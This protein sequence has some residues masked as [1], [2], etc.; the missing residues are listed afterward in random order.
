MLD[1]LVLEKYT[2][3]RPWSTIS[4]QEHG[5]IIEIV[6]DV[7]VAILLSLIVLLCWHATAIANGPTPYVEH[8]HVSKK[9]TYIPTLLLGII[10]TFSIKFPTAIKCV[11]GPPREG[12]SMSE[13]PPTHAHGYRHYNNLVAQLLRNTSSHHQL[14]YVTSFVT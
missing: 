11:G 2:T 4:S 14:S 13:P 5:S 8:V 1:S 6:R 3:R 12:E 10:H 9:M 7:Y